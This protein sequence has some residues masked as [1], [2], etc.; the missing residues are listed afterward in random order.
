MTTAGLHVSP[1]SWDDENNRCCSVAP[2]L[3]SDA[4]HAA[5]NVPLCSCSIVGAWVYVGPPSVRLELYE[6][7]CCTC[8]CFKVL[9]D[10]LFPVAGK[11][12]KW[13]RHSSLLACSKS[14]RATRSLTMSCLAFLSPSWDHFSLTSPSWKSLR[15]DCDCYP[16]ASTSEQELGNASQEDTPTGHSGPDLVETAPPKGKGTPMDTQQTCPDILIDR[17]WPITEAPTRTTGRTGG[18]ADWGACR[19]APGRLA[20]R[21][22]VCRANRSRQATHRKVQPDQKQQQQQQQRSLRLLL[23]SA[24]AAGSVEHS[25][26]VPCVHPFPGFPPDR[27]LIPIGRPAQ[28]AATVERRAGAWRR[29]RRAPSA[30][31]WR[32]L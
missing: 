16:G 30:R 8:A 13:G 22:D 2:S 20:W 31:V 29:G 7:N 24:T 3:V 12:M 19:T 10:A 32:E 14:L 5:I 9:V 4:C 25:C 26:L 17:C 18:R 15:L 27:R 11:R 28:R 23:V 21:W 1:R 6:Y